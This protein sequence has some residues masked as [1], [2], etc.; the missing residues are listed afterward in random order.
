MFATDI[1]NILD[2]LIQLEEG[3]AITKNAKG[4][5][6]IEKIEKKD[7]TPLLTVEQIEKLPKNLRLLLPEFFNPQMKEYVLKLAHERINITRQVEKE[8]NHSVNF[9]LPPDCDTRLEKLI[10]LWNNT[11]FEKDEYQH[12]KAFLMAFYSIDLP[13][14][15]GSK[16][17]KHF[18]K[19]GTFIVPFAEPGN[20]Q[21]YRIDVP[22]CTH[23]AGITR[24]MK[25]I[26]G[27]FTHGN[28]FFTSY[29]TTTAA[30][31][32]KYCRFATD[33]EIIAYTVIELDVLI[34]K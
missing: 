14:F 12:W 19:K 15:H 9:E 11:E 22:F 31:F 18:I 29:D 8:L 3:Q 17:I 30:E 20:N 27:D 34:D 32:F 2:K 25:R 16:F 21:N 4:E 10:K 7:D 23:V 13:A 1:K 26:Y 6:L 28:N 33:E 5:F 24:N